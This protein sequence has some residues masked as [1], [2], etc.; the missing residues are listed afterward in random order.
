MFD[1]LVVA[2]YRQFA[3]TFSEVFAAHSENEH[4]DGEAADEY[5]L[6]I[7]VEYNQEKFVA[8]NPQCDVLIARG[9]SAAL[10][11]RTYEY[12]PVVE[13]PVLPY[14]IIRCLKK[15]KEKYGKHKIV[16]PA[17][18]TMSTHAEYLS[19]LLNLD[20]TII[21]MPS[22]M[23][24]EPE[25][26]FSKICDKD[27]VIIGG[28]PL[29]DMAGKL[30]YPHIMIESGPEAMRSA[31]SEAKRLVQVRRM[32]QV[33]TK[34]IKAVLDYHADGIVALDRRNQ[35]MSINSMAEKILGIKADKA[36]RKTLDALFP[37]SELGEFLART[38]RC[39]DEV[40][41]F[42]NVPL[43][44]NKTAIFLDGEQMG[45]VVTLQFLA[46]I[47]DSEKNIRNKIMAKGHVARHTF[48][49][50]FGNCP[51]ISQAIATSRKYAKVDSSLLITGKSGTGKELF[52]QSIHNESNQK[53]YPFVAINCAAIPENLLESELFGYEEG[54][55]TG[56]GKK[57]KPGLIEL[58]HMG[59]LFLDEI[60]EMPLQ[61]QGRLLRVLQEHEIMR[62][63]SD[64]ITHVDI[65]VISAT[66][67]DL[68]ALVEANR[69]REDLYYRLAVLTLN[70]PSLEER[71]EDIPEL[72]ELFLDNHAK[73]A[74]R[75]RF[76]I[77]QEAMALLTKLPWPGNI[78]ELRNVCEQLTVLSET[79]HIDLA[80]VEIVA[81]EKL[82]RSQSHTAKGDSHE[83]ITPTRDTVASFIAK[84]FSKKMIAESLDI[85]R[86]T[87]WRKMRA[88]GMLQ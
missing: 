2:P 44:I 78:R 59:T 20:I 62:L 28:M 32:E 83:K 61:L 18:R 84:G 5:R 88:W 53:R 45:S 56:A 41:V 31:I 25:I 74:K 17:T 42:N 72:V 50:I 67:K 68:F 46:K 1:I 3:D 48:S 75:T 16:F 7:V 63:G 85:D 15:A 23:G 52:A 14:D 54:A 33:Q 22:T 10:L 40:L 65:R 64:K 24:R 76:T 36:L 71:Q 27:C 55:F 70:L 30:G 12:L 39:D 60:S 21:D 66:N 6:N 19:A 80:D 58:A 37:G 82:A 73:R 8:M 11:K 77:K 26:A 29:C 81:A 13:V 34:S 9:F 38:P 43:V 51:G 86:S 57:G 79:G 69:F 47:Q 49:N 4:S 87:L 35:I